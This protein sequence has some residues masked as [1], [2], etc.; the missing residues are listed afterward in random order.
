[1]YKYMPG[2]RSGDGKMK[3]EYDVIVVGAG[4]AGSIAAR[5]AA[6]KGCSVLLIEKRQEIGD[7]VRCGEGCDKKIVESFIDLDPRW[8]SAEVDG[9]RIFS[10]DGTII[11]MGSDGNKSGLVLERKIFDMALAQSAANAGVDICVK[12]SA[13]GLLKNDGFISGI[14]VRYLGEETEIKSKIVVG[15]D[16]VESKVGRWAGIDTSLKLKDIES[17]TQFL[18]TNVDINQNFCDFFVGNDI[19]PGGYAWVFPKGKNTANI[20]VGVIGSRTNEIRPIDCLKRFVKKKFPN[21]KVLGLIAGA[22]PLR[23]SIGKTVANG[24]ILVGDSA[25]QSDPITG[26]GI[27]NAMCCAKIA[28]NVITEAVSKNDSSTKILSKYEKEWRSSIGKTIDKNYKI[29]ELFIKMTDKQF[30]SLAQSLKDIKFN[31]AGTMTL[32]KQLIKNNPRM[33]LGL[34]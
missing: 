34:I 20:G 29:K 7:P 13:I 23:G 15:A 19:A 16:G 3:D 14:K 30:N 31:E 24:L 18:M 2:R 9:V 25:R 11:H 8:I 33:L 12:T 27:C 5:T 26:G 4:P 6:E 28:G 10:P 22:V 32:M 1:M 17:C 21:G